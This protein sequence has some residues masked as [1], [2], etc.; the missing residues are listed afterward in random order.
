MHLTAQQLKTIQSYFRAASPVQRAWL[1]GSFARG[2]AD[3]QS[4][5]DL[6]VDLDYQQYIGSKLF[7]WPEELANL[8]GCKVDV[9]PEDSLFTRFRP[10]VNADKVLIYEKSAPY[11]E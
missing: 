7:L 3:G 4:D 10:F 2:E 8:L 6:L 1:F 5:V 11:P 9:V